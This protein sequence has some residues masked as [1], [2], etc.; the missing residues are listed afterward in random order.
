[1]PKLIPLTLFVVFF[2]P[3]LVFA[4][5]V[6]NL[7]TIHMSDQGFSPS[8]VEISKG[9]IVV[10]ENIG[11]GD[12]WPASDIH[13]THKIFPQFDPKRPINLGKSW[14]FKFDRAGSWTFHDHLNPQ[15]VGIILV[16]GSNKQITKSPFSLPNF[17]V[18]IMKFYYKIFPQELQSDLSKLNFTNLARDEPTITYWLKILGGDKVM[19]RLISD[20]GGGATLD[21]HQE[22]H[23]IGRLSYQLFAKEVFHK[24]SSA[25]HSGY[26]HGAME[27]FLFQQGTQNL[28]ENINSLCS[29]FP[30]SFT[31]FEC[32]HG[33]GHGILA[34]ENYDL[35]WALETCRQ[36]KDNFAQNSCFGGVFMENIVTAEGNGAG[37]SHQTSWVSTDPY[38]PCNSIDQSSDIQNQCYLMQ[39]S[40]MLDIADHNFETVADLCLNVPD[41]KK[42]T[43]FQS[44]GRDAAGQ[45]LRDPDKILNICSKVDGKFFNDCILGALNVIVDFW[46]DEQSG[47]ASQFCGKISD[48]SQKSNCFRQL[49]GRLGEVF[50]D[51]L[52]KLRLNCQIY[53]GFINKECLSVAGIN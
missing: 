5:S 36:L 50:A 12:H 49:G 47:Q 4:H 22:A 26:Y 45:T 19:A 34:Y 8:K 2:L 48:N 27:A 7:S 39:T 15:F 41:S 44:L 13:P 33:V 31:K 42:D 35:P 51:D 11:K 9:E 43:C 25:C 37:N 32:L 21:C 23:L 29:N 38:F 28:S 10:F 16:S 3:K 20:S 6:D 17:K 30:T 1:M 46:G 52:D 53:D 24:G 40:R 14:Q 18:W